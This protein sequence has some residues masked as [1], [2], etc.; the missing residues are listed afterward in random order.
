MN[1][2][3]PRPCSASDGANR[4][5]AAGHRGREPAAQV[6]VDLEEPGPVDEQQMRTILR[7]EQVNIRGMQPLIG[8]RP[9]RARSVENVRHGFELP[10]DAEDESQREK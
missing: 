1:R 5:P 3:R 6:F 10:V 9:S 8:S 7:V 4:F 2:V